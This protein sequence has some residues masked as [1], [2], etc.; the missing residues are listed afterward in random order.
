MHK[1]VRIQILRTLLDP[2]EVFKQPKN[3]S[4]ES[5]QTGHTVLTENKGI[6]AHIQAIGS[7]GNHRLF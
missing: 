7:I 3:G 2:R 6:H 5:S 4:L 1:F